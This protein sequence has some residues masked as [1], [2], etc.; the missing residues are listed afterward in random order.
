MGASCQ[1]LKSVRHPT[2]HP[3]SQ[4]L[5]ILANFDDLIDPFVFWEFEVVLLGYFRGDKTRN[6]GGVSG[7]ADRV[8]VDGGKRGWGKLTDHR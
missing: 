7:E 1:F 2:M 4:V 3:E 5:P 6:G 8:D